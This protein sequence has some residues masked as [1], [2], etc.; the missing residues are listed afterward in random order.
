MK[1][2]TIFIFLVTGFLGAIAQQPV[3]DTILPEPVSAAFKAKY[4]GQS[5]DEWA[6]QG[7]NYVI[8]FVKEGKWIETTITVKG[9]WISE[10]IML[11]YS[12]LPEKIR[13]SFE[14]SPYANFEINKILEVEN[15]EVKKKGAS[16]GK[17][18]TIYYL[19]SNDEEQSVSYDENGAAVPK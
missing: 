5:A 3:A 8:T 15:G 1:V 14:A 7:E 4:S 10:N 18:Y 13:K 17:S 12:D 16:P 9:K 19:N 11:N 6:K 2:L